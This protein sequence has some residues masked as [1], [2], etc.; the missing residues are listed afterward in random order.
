MKPAGLAG[1]AQQRHLRV[2]GLMSGTSMDG[3]DIAVV[4]IALRT[5]Q[6]EFEIRFFTSVPFPEALKNQ[7]RAALTG[8]T[9]QVCALNYDLGRWYAEAV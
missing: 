4:D 1:L 7:I 2:L 6:A 8:T 5:D 9:E 3:L